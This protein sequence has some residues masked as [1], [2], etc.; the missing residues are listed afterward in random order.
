MRNILTRNRHLTER[1]GFIG[2]TLMA[3]LTVIPIIAT[4][5]YILIQGGPAISWEFLTGFPHDGMR[6]GGNLDDAGKRPGQEPP[7]H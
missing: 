3:V 4:V 2:I 5:I 7:A 6:A 1:I